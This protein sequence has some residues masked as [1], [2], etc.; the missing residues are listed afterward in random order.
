MKQGLDTWYANDLADIYLIIESIHGIFDV[1]IVNQVPVFMH[2][3]LYFGSL[4][5]ICACISVVHF[6]ELL[7]H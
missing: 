1:L 2:F 5:R 6:V 3:A 4:H 7:I